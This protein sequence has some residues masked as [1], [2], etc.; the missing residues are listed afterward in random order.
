M[1]SI[2]EK[3]A[4]IV[5][6]A[7]LGTR[8]KSDKAKVLHEIN[9]IPM[10]IRIIETIKNINDQNIVVVVGYQAEKVKL[11]ISENYDVSFAM[12]DRQLG[13]GHA[14]MSA[15]PYIKNNIEKIVI[16][17]G[18]VPLIKTETLKQ[19]IK[20]HIRLNCDMTI[21]SV[22]IKE[23][24]GYGRIVLDGKNLVS[25]IV[26]EAD[27]DE[28]EKTINTINSGIYCIQKEFLLNSINKIQPSNAQGEFYF[29]DIID[30]GYKEK[31]KIETIQIGKDPNEFMGVN[32]CEEL[33]KAE[34]I[35]SMY[36]HKRP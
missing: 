11:I 35:A 24:K 16:L 7:G 13:T 9:G 34:K 14:V 31:R 6:A 1:E 33:E 20:D 23:P 32:S 5:L 36:M 30:I 21:I 18:D 25:K 10:I 15:I 26:E 4:F 17:C 19:L 29:T 22:E 27:A 3:A 8:M 28:N 2:F 12:Q